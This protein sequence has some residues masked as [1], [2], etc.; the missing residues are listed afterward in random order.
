M[1]PT[2][3][4]TGERTVSSSTRRSK[5]ATTP[6]WRSTS[7]SLVRSSKDS[8]SACIFAFCTACS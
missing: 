1:L 5:L 3:P 2:M 4:S 8:F 7:S 6:R